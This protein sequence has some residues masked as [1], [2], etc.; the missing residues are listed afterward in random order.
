MKLH[1]LQH[2]AFEGLANV[3]PWAKEKGFAISRT[4][5][6]LGEELPGMDDF[7]WLVVMGGPMNIYEENLFPWLAA[8]KEFIAEAIR[9]NKRVI[10][11]CLGAQ[12]I[13]DVLG[14][15]VYRN[16]YKEIGWGQVSLTPEARRSPVFGTLPDRFTAFHWH[17]DTFRLAPGS[18][19]MAESEGCAIQAFEYNEGKVIGLQFHLE[20]SPE[21]VQT[22]ID[23]CGDELVDGKYIQKAEEI[24]SRPEAYGEIRELMTV[25]LD[26]LMRIPG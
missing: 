18:G 4:R 16:Q 12:L 2:V 25:L 10:G 15:P 9:S 24:L 17:G 5:L 23:H 20:S 21:S 1:Y 14:G 19:R 13:S 11:I 8:E 3:E 7:D 22:L 6:F 26:N